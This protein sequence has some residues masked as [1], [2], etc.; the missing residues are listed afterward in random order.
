MSLEPNSRKPQYGSRKPQYRAPG[1]FRT[2]EEFREAFRALAPDL[3]CDVELRGAE[4]PLARSLQV[5]DRT[6]GNRFV[7]HPMEGW[8][9]TRD[10]RPT[11]PTL[12][13]WRHFG[14][15][16]AKLIW[17]GEAFAVQEDGRANP[18]QLYR[19]PA[20]D[21]LADLTA[22]R[23]E[24]LDGHREGDP[25]ASTD[26]LMIGLQL[27]HSGRFSRPDGPAAPKLAHRH[28]PLEAKY[29]V[30]PNHPLLTDGELEAIG[31]S[32]VASA[33]LVRDA[34]F[35]FV[36]VKCCH[37]YL[38]HELLAARSRPGSYGG[39]FEG[40]T[41]FFRRVV[42]EIQRETPGLA[43]GCRLSVADL[44]PFSAREGD[45]V[46]EPSGWDSEL[47]YGL[48]FGVDPADPRRFDLTEPFAFFE[49]LKRLG[50]PLVN[51]TIGSPY[52]CPH[53][54][55]PAAYPPSDGYRPPEDPLFGVAT[56]LRVTRECK[57]AHPD[58]TFVGTGYSYL[59]EYLPH[60]AQHE[61][62]AGHVDAIGYGRM[63][64]IYPELA[65]DVLAGRAL[66]RKK[67]CRTF[68][69]CTT[70]PRNGLVSGCYPL[71]PYYK[72]HEDA[73]PLRAIKKETP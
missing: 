45:R 52:Y 22:L 44:Y 55:R 67:I 35:D 54:Q 10:G 14:F 51:L 1:K 48:G 19:N 16:G 56:H 20:V 71:D 4:G 30:D 25:D 8:D 41:R 7:M 15:S 57:A 29:G 21:T 26:D 46:G 62:G 39:S 68:S 9:G 11:E 43:I 53:V 70:A 66:V 27:T 34:G 49:L 18:Q 6:V 72:S 5:G 2:A 60:V 61:V 37:G 59:Q 28:P 69:D 32:F 31:E 17:G 24:I 12:R 47:P 58:L 13:R 64:I 65:R 38:L 33:R 50:I 3:D 73:A 63:A 23:S 36:D 40:R 42:E